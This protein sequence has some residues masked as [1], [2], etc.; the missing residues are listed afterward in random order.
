L[1][2]SFGVIAL[3]ELRP[4]EDAL[5]SHAEAL[6]VRALGRVIRVSRQA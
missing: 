1:L 5:E 3:V 6:V 4:R 2:P